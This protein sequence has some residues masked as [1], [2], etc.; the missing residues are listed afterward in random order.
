MQIGLI[1]AF[2]INFTLIIITMA[3]YFM[4]VRAQRRRDA[5]FRPHTLASQ[6]RKRK[7]ASPPE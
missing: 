7:P 3:L 4:H 1:W 6:R 5:K 2:L